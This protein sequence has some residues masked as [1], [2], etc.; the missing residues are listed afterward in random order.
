[1][2]DSKIMKDIQ[3]PDNPPGRL[4]FRNL[5]HEEQGTRGEKSV[6]SIRVSNTTLPIRV[7]GKCKDDSY[8]QH[9][10]RGLGESDTSLEPIV[11]IIENKQ[12]ARQTPQKMDEGQREGDPKMMLTFMGLQPLSLNQVWKQ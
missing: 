2:Q 5:F 7:K 11:S 9:E 3:V 12:H 6:L 4:L 10:P 1:M 8:T